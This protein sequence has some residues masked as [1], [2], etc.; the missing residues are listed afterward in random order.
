MRTVDQPAELPLDVA[1]LE[2][3]LRASD[4]EAQ[5]ECRPLRAS[6][7]ET[8]SMELWR[9]RRPLIDAA[10]AREARA[11]IAPFARVAQLLDPASTAVLLS[12]RLAAAPVDYVQLRAADFHRADA[13]ARIP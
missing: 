9:M 3:M 5:R 10:A 11:V 13:F 8:L 2:A 4:I 12:L 6:A 7:S 1:M